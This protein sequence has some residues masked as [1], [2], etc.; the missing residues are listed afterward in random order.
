MT[1]ATKADLT[2]DELLSGLAEAMRYEK[3][4]PDLKGYYGLRA[5]LLCRL[6]GCDLD[7]RQGELDEQQHAR[8]AAPRPDSPGRVDVEARYEV[9][10]WATVGLLND[11]LRLLNK[12]LS[13]FHQ[14][15]WLEGMP[16]RVQRN[17]SRQYGPRIDE[18]ER[19]LKALYRQVARDVLEYLFP[20]VVARSFP[21]GRLVEM[22]LPAEP[23]DPIDY[24]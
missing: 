16:P 3:A 20:G 17:L 13:P 12:P 19:E 4:H 10:G 22:G 7:R 24:F 11:C 23:P 2:V 1:D 5:Q 15:V 14:G 21:A 6:F 18:K 9:S 8:S